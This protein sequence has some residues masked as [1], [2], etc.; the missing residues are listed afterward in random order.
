[1]ACSATFLSTYSLAYASFASIAAL[2]SHLGTSG[3]GV[4]P[5]KA[6]TELV[7]PIELAYEV[8]MLK[9]RIERRTLPSERVKVTVSCLA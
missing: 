4:M 9:S 6:A 2:R 1:M 5:M 7:S 8:Y 3:T